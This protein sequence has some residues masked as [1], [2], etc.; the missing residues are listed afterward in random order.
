MA[1]AHTLRHTG[2]AKYKTWV[3]KWQETFRYVNQAH[4]ICTKNSAVYE[5]ASLYFKHERI[6]KIMSV[7]VALKTTMNFFRHILMYYNSGMHKSQ[8]P[9]RLCK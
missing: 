8:L 2:H 4:K 1:I 3:W 5:T 9:D 7:T 6:M